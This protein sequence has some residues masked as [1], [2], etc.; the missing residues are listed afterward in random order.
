MPNQR[1][2]LAL[3][4]QGH[5]KEEA[6][7]MLEILSAV[8]LGGGNPANVI[9]LILSGSLP[10]GMAGARAPVGRLRLA[11]E[12]LASSAP[13]DQ[14]IVGAEIW[15]LTESLNEGSFGRVERPKEFDG[16]TGSGRWQAGDRGGR[17]ALLRS[18]CADLAIRAN[19]PGRRRP[20]E[21]A[22]RA[23]AREDESRRR[24]QCKEALLTN[25]VRD[26]GRE[27]VAEH[28]GALAEEEAC[29]R[30]QACVAAAGDDVVSHDRPAEYDAA[31]KLPASALK[32][33]AVEAAYA[34]CYDATTRDDASRDDADAN[35]A[36][37]SDLN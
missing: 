19:C 25:L 24:Q 33:G 21:D 13:L 36:T 12:L 8:L 18:V 14:T 26:T 10:E 35:A 31:Q 2:W 7:T 15:G 34:A 1:A 28:L 32:A 27:A 4:G 22:S 11:A 6:M 17:F 9:G 23:A 29:A 30:A 16:V 3:D 37:V 20:G 5:D